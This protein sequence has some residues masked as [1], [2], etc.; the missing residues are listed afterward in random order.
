[1]QNITADKVIFCCIVGQN[2][3]C[4]TYIRDVSQSV[5]FVPFR[6]VYLVSSGILQLRNIEMNMLEQSK[7][8]ISLSLLFI[9]KDCGSDGQNAC[10]SVCVSV[11]NF[12]RVHAFRWRIQNILL[13]ILTFHDLYFL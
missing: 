2:T 12:Y 11:C 8:F 3:I 1:M 10:V 9:F 4:L 6:D 5:Q 7:L 13:T